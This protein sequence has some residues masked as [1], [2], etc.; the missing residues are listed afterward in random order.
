M[1]ELIPAMENTGKTEASKTVKKM[2]HFIEGAVKII[3]TANSSKGSIDVGDVAYGG[4]ILGVLAIWG[5]LVTSLEA[6]SRLGKNPLFYE[7]L[8]M[9]QSQYLQKQGLLGE[10]KLAE[11]KEAV[12]NSESE[13]NLSI[14]NRWYDGEYRDMLTFGWK[15][16]VNDKDAWISQIPLDKVRF[17][18]KD[19]LKSVESTIV[20]KKMN[21]EKALNQG[22]YHSGLRKDENLNYYIPSIELAIVKLNQKDFNNL[23][24]QYEKKLPREEIK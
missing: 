10:H 21:P 14:E 19:D 9:E 22:L 8:V 4:M 2:S 20:F 5:G 23:A 17:E 6:D 18:V 12:P 7:K 24:N 3:R 11:F 13:E 15:P 1:K 16:K